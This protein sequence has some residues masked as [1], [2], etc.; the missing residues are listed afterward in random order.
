MEIVDFTMTAGDSKT[1]TVSVTEQSDG[2]ATNITG[3]TISWKAAR[4][5]RK[6][7]VLTK[8]TAAGIAITSGAGGTFDITLD[9]SDT[10]SLSGDFYHE[11]KV[12][13]T[14]GEVATV[15]RGVMTISPGF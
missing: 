4:S 6:S 12:T 15:L 1:V 11:A 3:A 5:L 7:P 14:T 8:T 9:P 13:F 2:A 10:T